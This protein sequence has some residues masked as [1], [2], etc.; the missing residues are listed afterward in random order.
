MKRLSARQRIYWLKYA[1]RSWKHD[2]NRRER[3]VKSS[4]ER[5]DSIAKSRRREI[6]AP[7]CLDLENNY[8]ETVLFYNQLRL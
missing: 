7:T 1:F 3:V 5:S 2:L 8:D 6:N 4:E